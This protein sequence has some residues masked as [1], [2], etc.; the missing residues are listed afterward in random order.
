MQ[1]PVQPIVS[2]RMSFLEV[3]KGHLRGKLLPGFLAS[4]SISKSQKILKV[5]T[6]PVTQ[7]SLGV[8]QENETVSVNCHKTSR[9]CVLQTTQVHKLALLLHHLVLCLRFVPYF[10]RTVVWVHFKLADLFTLNDIW[11]DFGFASRKLLCKV[12]KITYPW[13]FT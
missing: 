6:V 1:P 4:A 3:S 13:T 10:R 12:V 5:Y 7:F 11:W 2:H 8:K 9:P